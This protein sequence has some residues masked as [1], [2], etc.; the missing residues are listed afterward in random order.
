MSNCL[1]VRLQ[2]CR[3]R[4]AELTTCVFRSKLAITH[5]ASFRT[6]FVCGPFCRC[7][8]AVFMQYF[9]HLSH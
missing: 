5:T 9:L 6:V 1:T 8:V 2:T 3:Q 7:Y 4:L